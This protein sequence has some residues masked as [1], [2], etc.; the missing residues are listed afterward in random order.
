MPE[1]SKR[2]LLLHFQPIFYQR[3]IVVR[4]YVFPE[5]VQRKSAAREV[6]KK[7]K[8]AGGQGQSLISAVSRSANAFRHRVRWV[9]SAYREQVERRWIVFEAQ[10]SATTCAKRAAARGGSTLR[11]SRCS[12]ESNRADSKESETLLDWSRNRLFER[13]DWNGT[14]LHSYVKTLITE[15]N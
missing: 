2:K 14:L 15:I 11:C 3:S 1:R 7:A 12:D 13:L 8:G 9:T 4:S 10:R 6:E 5:W